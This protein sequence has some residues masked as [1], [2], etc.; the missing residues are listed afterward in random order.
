MQNM[1]TAAAAAP[2]SGIREMHCST[3]RTVSR[4][5]RSR[6]R[7]HRLSLFPN[8][9]HRTPSLHAPSPTLR[10]FVMYLGARMVVLSARRLFVPAE[11]HADLIIQS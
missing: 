11:S 5:R 6:R 7:Q 3:Q 4:C 1:G 9:N 8:N 2:P 10:D